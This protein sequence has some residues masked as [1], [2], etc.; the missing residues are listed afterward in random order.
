MQVLEVTGLQHQGKVL[1]LIFDK[2]Q[3]T[4][5]SYTILDSRGDETMFNDLPD[6]ALSPA[7]DHIGDYLLRECDRCGHFFYRDND[8]LLPKEANELDCH[9]CL[10]YE[11]VI[12]DKH[13]KTLANY[14]DS[15]STI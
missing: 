4:R 1:K 7:D 13:Y 3:D 15:V 10:H 2:P 6:R 8:Y 14:S 12:S 5:Y 9:D 11:G